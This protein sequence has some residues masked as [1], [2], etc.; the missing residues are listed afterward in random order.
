MDVTGLTENKVNG[1]VARTNKYAT[2]ISVPAR[3]MNNDI[4]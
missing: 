3:I 2:R 1:K 4:Y